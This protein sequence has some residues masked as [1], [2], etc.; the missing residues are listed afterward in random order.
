[1]KRERIASL[2]WQSARIW[3]IGAVMSMGAP[4]AFGQYAPISSP[5]DGTTPAGNQPEAPDGPFT[6]PGSIKSTFQA[7]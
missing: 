3:A 4:A 6:C 7:I 5:F 2:G 1:M